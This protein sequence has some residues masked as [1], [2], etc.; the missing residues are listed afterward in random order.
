MINDHLFQSRRS[1]QVEMKINCQ[2]DDFAMLKTLI[3]M[4]SVLPPA[5]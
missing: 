3:F 4:F 1:V 5:L 2:I